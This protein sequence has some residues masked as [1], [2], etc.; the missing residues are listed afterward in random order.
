MIN[1]GHYYLQTLSNLQP[2]LL[3]TTN[4]KNHLF[5]RSIM[6]NRLRFNSTYNSIFAFN[7]RWIVFTKFNILKVLLYQNLPFR[8]WL[9]IK[10]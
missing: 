2:P 5:I 1:P 8:E 9:D 6:N 4:F 3:M 7:N 10:L